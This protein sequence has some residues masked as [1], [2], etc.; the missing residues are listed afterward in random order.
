MQTR[1]DGDN[2]PAASFRLKLS[3]AYT[4][5]SSILSTAR[6][7]SA[8][9]G[10]TLGCAGS[11]AAISACTALDGTRLPTRTVAL[12]QSRW[13]SCWP[14]SLDVIVTSES[15]I[16]SSQISGNSR[17]RTESKIA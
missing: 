5:V 14:L 10:V 7:S 17:S 6:R 2:R 16:A 8:S 11:H 9:R 12:L 3:R 15:G 13:Y 4:R 1:Q